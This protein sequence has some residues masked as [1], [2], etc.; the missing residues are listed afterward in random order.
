ML[1][2]IT[3]DKFFMALFLL[4]LAAMV[5]GVTIFALGMKEN[6]YVISDGA[7]YVVQYLNKPRYDSH[8]QGLVFSLTFLIAGLLLTAIILIP[9]ANGAFGAQFAGPPQPRQRQARPATP[10]QAAIQTATQAAPTQAPAPQAAPPPVEAL[11]EAVQPTAPA[12]AAAGAA[13]PDAQEPQR[14][15]KPVRSVEEEV[16][17]QNLDDLPRL[18]TPDSR[19]EDT[20]EDDVVYGS[21]RVTDDSL[22]E[23]V[24]RHPDSAVKFLYRKTLDNKPLSTS[25]EEIYRRWEMRGMTRATVRRIV[26]E[27]MNWKAL[28][29]DFPHNICRELRDQVFELRTR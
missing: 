22:W 16:L 9:S 29:E 5:V 7:G 10:A 20:G 6:T 8:L 4:F 27:I 23:F 11:M 2:R 14:P 25:D 24:E 13:T 28:P 12:M 26:L 15:A 19:F 1:N 18:D 21:G 3:T 17:A